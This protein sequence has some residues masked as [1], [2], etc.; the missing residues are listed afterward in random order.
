VG[1]NLKTSLF[2]GGVDW[3]QVRV[4]PSV[5]VDVSFQGCIS[6]L[7]VGGATVDLVDSAIASKNVEECSNVESRACDLQTCRNAGTCRDLGSTSFQCSCPLGFTGTTCETAVAIDNAAKFSGNGSYVELPSH[8]LPHSSATAVET[9]K[10]TVS[11][12]QDN[13]LLLWHGQTPSMPG[14]G[15]DYVTLAIVNG[16]PQFSYELGSGPANITG[17]TRVNDGQEHE[18]TATRNGKMGSLKIDDSDAIEGESR[19]QLVTLNTRGN[20][21]I[22]GLPDGRLMT[23]GKFPYTF[24]GCISGVHIQK[25]GPLNMSEHAVKGVNVRP[26]SL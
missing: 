1:L 10:L 22:G 12:L 9:I 17:S 14:R 19:G 26:C 7:V 13:A 25:V 18:L 8:L 24:V 23:A 20:I 6:E 11:T 15:R 21:Y 5:G 3:T 2:V 16:F 4:S